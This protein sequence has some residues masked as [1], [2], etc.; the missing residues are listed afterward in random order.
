MIK[1]K[2]RK[3]FHHFSPTSKS[4]LCPSFGKA[5]S[6][7]FSILYFTQKFK[8]GECESKVASPSHYYF[9]KNI[10]SHGNDIGYGKTTTTQ[11]NRSKQK[12]KKVL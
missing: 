8:G 10:F 7:E 2:R 6:K 9:T 11:I 4:Y 12:V 1:V 5:G 3:G